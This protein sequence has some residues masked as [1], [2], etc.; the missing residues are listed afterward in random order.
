MAEF[1]LDQAAGLRR[2]FGRPRVRI[3]TFAAGSSGVGT[4]V[5]VANLASA[6]A[7]GGRE[8][9]VIDE[10]S[11]SDMATLFGAFAPY[12]VQQV[13]DGQRTL[14]QVITAV[15]PG[16]RVLPAACLVRRLG[17]LNANEQQILVT[18]LTELTPAA[19]VVLV[20]SSLDHPLGFSPLGLA[21][22]EAVIVASPDGASITEAY[23]LIK[24]VSLGYARKQ[25]RILVNKSRGAIE[26]RAIHDN[27]A[28]VTASRGLGRVDF[29]GTISF[30]EH[31]RQAVRLRQPVLNLFPEAPAAKAFRKLAEELLSWPLVG[32]ASGDLALFVQQLL[33][34]TQHIDSQAIYA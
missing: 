25:F 3:V 16:I 7:I 21:A 12:D 10:N 24:K 5:C 13:V 18:C 34:L 23:A 1:G 31:L 15:A 27:I 2:L 20:D 29:A 33:Y 6:L 19:D 17:H 28:R 14:A 30:D 11:E 4:S 26:A 22:Q 9:L 8:V 32:E